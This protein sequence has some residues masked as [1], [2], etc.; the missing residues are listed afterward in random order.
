M[1]KFRCLVAASCVWPLLAI[2]AAAQPS[3]TVGSAESGSARAEKF[4][5]YH[6]RK[7]GARDGF[8]VEVTPIVAVERGR[9]A[10]LQAF[11]SPVLPSGQRFDV[12]VGGTTQGTAHIVSW[13]AASS[14]GCPGVGVAQEAGQELAVYTRGLAAVP[15][16]SV[17]R[18]SPPRESSSAEKDTATEFARGIL[19]EESVPHDALSTLSLFGVYSVGDLDHNR[20]V[21]LISS[22]VVRSE[23]DRFYSLLLVLGQGPG[24][25]RVAKIAS[26]RR[27]RGAGHLIEERVV[28]HLDLDG[29]G[30]HEIIAYVSEHVGPRRASFPIVYGLRNGRWAVIYEGAPQSC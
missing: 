30:T 29:D 13:E 1:W 8:R 25:R 19:M 4:V 21:E 16:F 12:F 2:P 11:G 22:F 10:S 28:D 6:V 9:P 14:P 7:G 18:G 27:G 20:T 5:L 23:E 17:P 24:G 3:R 15:G 26:V